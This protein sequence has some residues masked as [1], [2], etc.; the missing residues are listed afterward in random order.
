MGRRS[1]FTLFD[2]EKIIDY[3]TENLHLT[4]AE[5]AKI[6]GYPQSVVQYA[7][8]GLIT[9]EDRRT[10]KL[11]Y[12]LNNEPEKLSKV[13]LIELV[14]VQ[15]EIIQSLRGTALALRGLQNGVD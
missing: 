3:Q 5:V 1:E 9:V 11:Q 12:R 13:E 8:G 6:L 14:K 4:V 7:V 2:R 15:R 10:A